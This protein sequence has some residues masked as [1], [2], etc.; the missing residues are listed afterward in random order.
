M[1]TRIVLTITTLTGII[2][3]KMPTHLAKTL[4]TTAVISIN[5][6]VVSLTDAMK[7][8]AASLRC[9]EPAISN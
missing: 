2:N 1:R 9:S 3:M 4:R 7:E 8:I 6:T 5:T